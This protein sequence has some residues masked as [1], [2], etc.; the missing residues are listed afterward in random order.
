MSTYLGGRLTVPACSCGCCC[1]GPPGIRCI[2]AGLNWAWL[3]IT[4]AGGTCL[5]RE[6]EGEVNLGRISTFYSGKEMAKITRSVD[7]VQS[8][9]VPYLVP[10]R[11][12]GTSDLPP[13]KRVPLS[14]SL[15]GRYPAERTLAHQLSW[16]FRLSLIFLG[17]VC[18]KLWVNCRLRE[19]LP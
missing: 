4:P 5:G 2:T 13:R 1:P 6:G 18:L 16:F 3:T 15:R 14:S 19:I 10:G 9:L 12:W 7:P 17:C 8:E 11:S